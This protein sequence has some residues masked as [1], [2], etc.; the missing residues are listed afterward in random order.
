MEIKQYKNN[1]RK[2]IRQKRIQ[3]SMEE[4]RYKSEIICRRILDSERYKSSKC[5]YCYYPIQNEVNILPV[6]RHALK[7]EKIVAL[8]KVIHKNGEMIFTEIENLDDLKTGYYNIPEPISTVQARKADV[9]LVPGVVFSNTGK[10][11]GQAG[12]FYDRFLEKKHPY[13]IGIAY[14]FQ[15]IN[16]LKTEPHDI[17][18]NQVISNL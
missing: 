2:K 9:I 1:F 16:D 13:S 15:I 18:V 5:I 8:P 14:D 12:G 10:R 4:V 6:I 11:I 17:D 3:M 7:T